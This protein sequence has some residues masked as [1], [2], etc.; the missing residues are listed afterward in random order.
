MIGTKIKK[1]AMAL[2]LQ[3]R[4][5][6][7]I[8]KMLGRNIPKSTFSTWFKG[9]RLPTE[10][11]EKIKANNLKNLVLARSASLLNNAIRRRKYLD[12]ILKNNSH[13]AGIIKNPDVAKVA[14]AMLFLAEGS[15]SKKASLTFCNSDPFVIELF[16][17]LLRSCYK[18]SEEKFRCTV[19]CRAD[20]DVHQLELFWSDV[21]HIP[22]DHFSKA[23]VD[24]RTIGKPTK[25]ETYKGVCR[26][27]Y[28]SAHIFN[29]LS[30]VTKI[31]YKGL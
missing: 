4:S 12:D 21:T 3:G 22:A 2:R 29:D 26:I 6:S 11:Q 15:K 16:L 20:Q 30:Q 25:K 9:L 17:H 24:K 5:Y 8:S 19:Q 23:Q 14:L 10:V 18:L 13:L 7:D 1:G 31:I 28:F 27:D